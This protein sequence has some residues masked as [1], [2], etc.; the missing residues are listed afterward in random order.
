MI[1]TTEGGILRCRKCGHQFPQ[2]GFIAEA[3]GKI[4]RCP[5]PE[6]LTSDPTMPMCGA[7]LVDCTGQTL[8]IGPLLFEDLQL[9]DF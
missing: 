3:G 7:I 1:I 5:N 9:S 4:L 2:D 6:T 8:N